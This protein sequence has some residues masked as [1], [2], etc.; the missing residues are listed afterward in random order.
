MFVY[1][2]LLGTWTLLNEHD[3]IE[4]KHPVDFISNDLMDYNEHNKF[5]KVIH[6]NQ[7]FF[8]HISQIQFTN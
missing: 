7:N 1:A 2:N 8:I 3:L 5:V 6:N 4:S